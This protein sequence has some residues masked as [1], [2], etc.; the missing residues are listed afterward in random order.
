MRHRELLTSL[1]AVGNELKVEIPRAWLEEYVESYGL[2]RDFVE[3]VLKCRPSETPD[4]YICTLAEKKGESIVLN[5][6]MLKVLDEFL[7]DLQKM[8]G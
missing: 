6:V 1:L 2:G 4:Y 7:R 5:V 8:L 3:K